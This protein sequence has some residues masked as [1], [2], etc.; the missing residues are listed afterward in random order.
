M[1]NDFGERNETT[2]KHQKA[3]FTLALLWI[4]DFI[5]FDFFSKLKQNFEKI[6]YIFK[7]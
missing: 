1:D 6:I 5:P 3:V 2:G 7:L 4:K